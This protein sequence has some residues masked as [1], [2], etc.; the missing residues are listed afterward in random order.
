MAVKTSS[1]RGVVRL[2]SPRVVRVL[3]PLLLLVLLAG[4]AAVGSARAQQ[5]PVITPLSPLYGTAGA[6]L[7][8]SAIPVSAPVSQYQW[9]FGDG[10]GGVGQ[11]ASHTYALP[12]TYTVTLTAF[13]AFGTI[14][15]GVTTATISPAPVPRVNGVLAGSSSVPSALGFLAVNAYGPYNGTAGAP[16]AFTGSASG[17]GAPQF[18]WDFGDGQGGAGATVSHTYGAPGTFI[19]RLT[20]IDLQ[21]GQSG[22]T[23]S[24]AIIA[25]AGATTAP[26]GAGAT[27]ISAGAPVIR[28]PAGWNLVAGPAGTPFPQALS[29]LYTWQPGDTTYETLRAE[30]GVQAGA[31]YWA[32]FPQ[33]ASVSLTGASTDTA[34]VNLS[35]GEVVLAGNP[36]ASATVTVRGADSAMAYDA[37]FARYRSV[38]S[39][40]PGAAAWVSVGSGG[41]VTLSP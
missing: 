21:T 38:Q 15:T 33:P 12:G 24:S 37:A 34:I 9:D 2:C 4:G 22:V 19:V 28:Y 11:T 30:A 31:G 10:Q 7:T 40:P 6:A 1:L 25:P 27:A 3:L 32:Y 41:T 8:F 17:S 18:T 20:V 16:V 35:P 36:S 39:L 13:G 14:A 5:Y 26:T 23:S 29:P